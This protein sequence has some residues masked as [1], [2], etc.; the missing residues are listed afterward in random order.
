MMTSYSCRL[1]NAFRRL[2]PKA[3]HLNRGLLLKVKTVAI[4]FRLLRK[5][6]LYAFRQS[7]CPQWYACD[8][9]HKL[10]SSGLLRLAALVYALTAADNLDRLVNLHVL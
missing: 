2:D 4:G 10:T 1:C 6:W 7:L 3:M 8:L 5:Q 9:G